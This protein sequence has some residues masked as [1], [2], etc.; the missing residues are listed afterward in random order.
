MVKFS[1]FFPFPTQRLNIHCYIQPISCTAEKRANK[2]DGGRSASGEQETRVE[3]ND[4]DDDDD[5]VHGKGVGRRKYSSGV[6]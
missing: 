6:G 1:L 5:N 2:T 3:H 4:D